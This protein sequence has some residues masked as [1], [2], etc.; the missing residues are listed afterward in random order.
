MKSNAN[1]TTV[2]KF[3]KL[4]INLLKQDAGYSNTFYVMLILGIIG[5]IGFFIV[6][7]GAVGGMGG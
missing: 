1:A 5:V 4:I 2:T 3:A 6:A 7:S